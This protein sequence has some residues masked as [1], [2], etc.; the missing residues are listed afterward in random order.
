MFPR[1]APHEVAALPFG[2]YA[3]LRDYYISTLP[4]KS[5]AESD[6]SD[7]DFDQ[8]VLRGEPI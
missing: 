5:E 1:F 3:K 4:E 8:E 7:F 6:D 2:Y